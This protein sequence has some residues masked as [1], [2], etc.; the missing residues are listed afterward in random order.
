MT[1]DRGRVEESDRRRALIEERPEEHAVA[2]PSE[3]IRL[4][5]AIGN[6]AFASVARAGALRAR[7]PQRSVQR[8]V[9]GEHK[10]IGDLGSSRGPALPPT[11]ELGP[12]LAVSYGDI[13][14]MGAT[15]SSRYSR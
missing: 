12:G 6:R 15:G 9:E 1:A 11:L 4:A 2:E 3:A 8:F 10:L 13:V 5:S 14:A 7:P